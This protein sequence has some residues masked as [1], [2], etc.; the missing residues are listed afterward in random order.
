M[1][2][3]TTIVFGKKE[4]KFQVY[5]PNNNTLYIEWSTKAEMRELLRNETILANKLIVEHSNGMKSKMTT[6]AFFN[7]LNT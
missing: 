5:L 6:R 1:N 2:N 7:F 4:E 3:T